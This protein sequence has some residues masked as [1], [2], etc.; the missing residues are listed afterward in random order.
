[1]PRPSHLSSDN[2][3]RF[4]QVRSNAASQDE[5]ARGLHIRRADH[6]PLL[7]MLAR[8][9]KRGLIEELPGGRYRL[10]VKS[11]GRG[12]E[13]TSRDRSAQNLPATTSPA[14]TSPAR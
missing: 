5:I 2:I 4:L 8:L 11:D 14:S 13:R 3:L 9:K 10:P 7:D 6:R 12:T 1:M